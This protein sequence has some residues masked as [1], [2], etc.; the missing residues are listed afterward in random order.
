MSAGLLQL[1]LFAGQQMLEGPPHHE[2][3]LAE[4]G[5]TICQITDIRNKLWKQHLLRTASCEAH[6]PQLLKSTAKVGHHS[7]YTYEASFP[8]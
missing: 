7:D 2:P 8:S 1:G 6:G 4:R 3:S 5:E